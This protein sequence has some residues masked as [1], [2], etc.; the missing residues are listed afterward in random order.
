M[1]ETAGGTVA[2]KA[3]PRPRFRTADGAVAP[4]FLA[5]INEALG[6]GDVE[7]LRALTRKLPEAD[8]GDLVAALDAAQRPRLVELLGKDFDFAALTEVDESVR[9]DLLGELPP[10]AVAAGVREL[11]SDDAVY[12]LKNLPEEN[13]AEILD[14]LPLPER[15][16]LEQSLRYPPESAG[17]RMQTEFIALPPDWTVGDA[18][19]YLRENRNLPDSFYELY[20]VAPDRRLLGTVRLDRLLR[21]MRP[22]KIAD[23]LVE[24]LRTVQASADQ[25]HAAREFDRYN[26]VSAPVVDEAGRLVGVLTADDVMEV[27]EEEA[28]EDLRALAGVARH[29]ELSDS[30]LRT[31]RSRLPWLALNMMTAFVAAAVIWYFEATIAAVVTV[32]ILMPVNAALGG[33]AGTQALTV[34]VR[35]L[36]TQELTRSNTGRIIVREA[37]VGVVNGAALACLAGAISALAFGN[38]KLGVVLASAMVLTII[39]ATTLGIL[40]PLALQRLRIDPAIASGVFVT[41]T[42]DVFGF[43]TFLGLATYAFGL[44]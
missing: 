8:L 21:S 15:A 16:A 29:E 24:D 38:L 30:V 32:A 23:I 2:P 34:A 11:E 28:Q 42:T 35:A 43:F 37:L 9:E 25:E 26:L 22:V 1:N 39:F 27:L 20:A 44:M 14:R 17:R 7:R 6:Q 12:L 40:V 18:I 36:A 5:A 41:T 3:R 33:N 10:A 13:Q 19:D 31:S 4:R